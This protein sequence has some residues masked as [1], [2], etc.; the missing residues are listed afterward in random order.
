MAESDQ[1]V[2][3]YAEVLNSLSRA[4]Y[5]KTLLN[6]TKILYNSESYGGS[7]F[8]FNVSNI[9]SL[10]RNDYHVSVKAMMAVI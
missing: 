5:F 1:V 9:K 6:F 10:K 3:Y 8:Y 2:T 7:H 4:H